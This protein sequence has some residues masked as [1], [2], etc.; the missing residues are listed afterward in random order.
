MIAVNDAP[1][2]ANASANATEDTPL[3]ASLPAATDVEGQTITYARSSNA[4]HGSVVVNAN[5]SYTYTPAANYFGPDSFGFSVSDGAGGSNTYT[6]TLSVAAVNDAPLASAGSASTSEDT[7]LNA[8]LPVA[9]DVDGDALSYSRSSNAAHGNVVVNANGSY[10]YTPA[11]NY[12]G[13]DAFGY[14]V[15]DGQ[16]GSAS[17]TVTLNVASVNDLPVVASGSASINEDNVLNGNLP[18]ASDVDGDA[19]SYS[20]TSTPAHGTVVVNANGSYSYTPEAN[21]AGPDAFNFAVSDG[22]GGVANA[23]LSLTVINVVDTLVG[24]AGADLMPAYAGGDRY[25]ALGGNDTILPGAGD[26]TIDGGDGMDRVAYTGQLAPLIGDLATGSVKIGS[27]T[28]TLLNVEALWGGSGADRLIGNS[29][30]NAFFGG[31]GNDS[32]DGAAGFDIVSVQGPNGAVVNLATGVATQAGNT[33][34]LSAIEAVFGSA[35]ADVLTGLNGLDTALGE[36]FRPVGGN[37]SIDGGS[38]VDTVEFTGPRAAYSISRP[39][40]ASDALSVTHNAASGNEGTD[41]LQGIERLLFTDRLVAFGARADELAKV[42]FVLWGAGAA[43]DKNL[44]AIGVNYY[45]TGVSYT[46]LIQAALSYWPQ[47]D[48]ALAAQLIGNVPGTSQTVAGLLAVM[49]AKGGGAAGQTEATRVMADDAANLAN[50]DRQGLRSN[51]IEAALVVDGT[52]KFAALLAGINTAP[53]A[54]AGNAAGVEDSLLNAT[55]PL[56]SDADGDNLV[57]GLAAAAAHGTVVV[58]ANGSYRYTPV[59]NF[60]GSDSFSY[61]V[62]DG[63]GGNTQATITLNVAAVNDAPTASPGSASLNEDSPYNGN[64]PLGQDIDGDALVYSRSS[65]AAHG[66]VAVNANGSFSYTPEANYSGSDSFEYTVSDGKG[67]SASALMNLTITSVVDVFN[68][69]PG[70]DAMPGYPGAD[71]YQGGAGNDTITP[72]LGDDSIDGGDGLDRVSYTERTA[73]INANLALGRVTIGSETDGLSNIEA[74]WGG[75]GNDSLTGDALNNAFYGGPGN[76][77]LDGAQGMDLASYVSGPAVNANLLTGLATQG[78]ETD[79]LI[80][81]EVLI[82]S[83]FADTFTGLDGPANALGEVFRPGGGNDSVNGGTGVD[84]VEFAGPRSAYSISRPSLGNDALTV[85]H[86]ISGGDGTDS[87]S[88]VERLLFS[89]RLVAFGSRAEELAKVAFVLWGAA[90]SDRNLFAV[91]FNYYDSGVTYGALINAALS[92]WTHLDN[93]ALAQRLVTDAPGTA[94]TA[95]ELLALMNGFVD[96]G[97]GRATATQ[98]MADDPANLANID[99]MGLRS[100]GIEAALIIDGAAVWGPWP[101]G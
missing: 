96:P 31:P 12:F 54:P 11:A 53:V 15:S 97:L 87:L 14:S 40:L 79:Q 47:N 5:G 76:D 55:L 30:A 25:N 75:S 100:N 84:R 61:L 95:A 34:A 32:I 43:G 22:K 63:Q 94:H 8:T 2:S 23:T 65:T 19:L 20:R 48:S 56:A 9:S 33:D 66:S 86:L 24:T 77:T 37:D 13:P 70:P 88:G 101:G 3:S 81:I 10:T 35:A 69:T 67:G 80:S 28:D 82:G 45:D 60:N 18:S 57:Y 72:G 62:S 98:L 26:D 44:F 52:V 38:G 73:A 99:L 46:T 89:D 51:G 50:I 42:V 39:S 7:P 85:S 4:A 21:Y 36:V 74:V 6:L 91:G 29:G 71:R 16:G 90:A 92:Y 41:A 93:A 27:E 49:T 78:S 68:G 1:I 58:N 64:L 17:A 83:A 59:T